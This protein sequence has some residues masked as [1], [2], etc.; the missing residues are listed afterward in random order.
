V[1]VSGSAE[2]GSSL[3]NVFRTKS[4]F[5]FHFIPLVYHCGTPV[6]ECKTNKDLESTKKKPRLCTEVHYYQLFPDTRM[7][8]LDVSSPSTS[9]YSSYVPAEELFLGYSIFDLEYF[10]CHDKYP[11]RFLVLA[12]TE[13]QTHSLLS[14]PPPSTYHSGFSSLDFVLHFL[15]YYYFF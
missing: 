6:T 9:S 13:G 2:G 4:T 5:I 14:F 3:H 1:D 15:I 11:L 10:L 12:M 7:V 8:H